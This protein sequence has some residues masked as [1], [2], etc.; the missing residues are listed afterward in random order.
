LVTV[1]IVG[2]LFSALY[3]F[4]M[5]KGKAVLESRIKELTKKEVTIG[6]FRMSA[7]LNAEIKELDI[8]GLAKIERIFVSPSITRLV[9]GRIVLNKV[10]IIRPE[11]NFERGAAVASQAS[12]AGIKEPKTKKKKKF[13]KGP[14]FRSL[15]IKEGRIYFSDHTVGPNGIRIT[16]KDINL[17]LTNAYIFP[18]STI[19]N[20]VLTGVIPWQEGKKEGSI[21][22][23]GWLNL[24]KKDMQA[25]LKI[26]SIDGVYLY[27]YYSNW[28]DLEKAGIESANLNFTSDINGLNNNITAECH[29]ELTDIVRKPTSPGEGEEKAAKIANGVLDIFRALNQGKVVLDFTIRTKMDKPQFGFADIKMAFEEKLN[30]ARGNGFA[31]QN[32]LLLPARLLTGTVKGATDFSRAVIEG[33]FAVGNEFKRAIQDTFKTEPAEEKKE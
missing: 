8:K 23:N 29:L 22:L 9:M 5:V 32:F 18:V 1:I 17:E 3:L 4:M 15:N 2:F 27:P 26:E 16:V 10:D 20:F 28:V 21:S 11:I 31:I 19:S 14:D 33:T 13:P 30:H 6:S 25:S 24:R 7:P 12:D